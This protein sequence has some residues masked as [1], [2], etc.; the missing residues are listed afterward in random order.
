MPPVAVSVVDEPEQI[1]TFEPPL[2]VG[3]VFTLTVTIAV[4]EQPAALVP[5]TVYV[6]VEPGLAVTLVPVVADKPV[7]GDH[8][9]V[10]PPVAV[11]VVD[12]PVQIATFEPPLIVGS[13]LT[14][15]VTVEVFAQPLLLVPVIV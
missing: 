14:V 3:S 13:G 10:L 15:I 11:S 6:V 5:V 1:A 9:Y 8:V 12:E 4:L 7:P 2:M